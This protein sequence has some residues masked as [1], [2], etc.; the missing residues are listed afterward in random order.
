MSAHAVRERYPEDVE[1]KL[2]GVE[3]STLPSGLHLVDEDIVWENHSLVCPRPR[4]QRR[5]DILRNTFIMAGMR[6]YR[7]E[8]LGILV[9]QSPRPRPWR[10]KASLKDLS[11]RLAD[12]WTQEQSHYHDRDTSNEKD[13]EILK[14]WFEKRMFRRIGEEGRWVGWEEEFGVE[15]E[16]DEGLDYKFHPAL[17]LPHILRILGPSSLTL[18]KHAL[19]QKRIL[20]YTNPPVEPACVLARI[21]ADIVG[22]TGNW[23]PSSGKTTDTR[24]NQLRDEQPLVLGMVGIIDVEKLI[25]HQDCGWIACT[26][27]AIFLEKP[28]LYDL[29]IDMT[30]TRPAR[31]AFFISK[32]IPSSNSL[33]SSGGTS[34]SIKY[35]LVPTRFTFS[36]VRLW[37]EIDRALREEQEEDGPENG[38]SL[39]YTP[40]GSTSSD[41]WD[42]WRIYEDVCIACASAWMGLGVGGSFGLGTSLG[43][44]GKSEGTVWGIGRSGALKVKDRDRMRSWG[45]HSSSSGIR[46]ESE[47]EGPGIRTLGRGI[48]G[49][50][51]SGPVSG[52]PVVRGL[53]SA[54]SSRGSSS[55]QRMQGSSIGIGKMPSQDGGGDSSDIDRELA[56][57]RQRRRQ[58]RTT[59]SLLSIFHGHSEFLCEKLEEVLEDAARRSGSSFDD[60]Y[61]TPDGAATHAVSSLNNSN[62]PVTLVLT[63]RDIA[64]MEL[65]VLSDLDARFLEWLADR[66][67]KAEGLGRRVVVRRGWRDVMGDFIMIDARGTKVHEFGFG[68][69]NVPQ[70][71]TTN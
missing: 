67:C 51:I 13:W 23:S 31:P 1:L 50:P 8:S 21:A 43:M 60:T 44:S 68:S 7:L 2:D 53:R 70:S 61:S 6:G 69:Q 46:L 39:P 42:G 32:A 24:S 14:E 49:R 59:L 19:A 71:S 58:I 18:Y 56:K 20:I 64:A 66:R 25:K 34:S 57:R 3:F 63:P 55:A 17:H 36:D 38:S 33:A 28:A 40:G 62:S 11:H 30:T 26:T 22:V 41:R 45:F 54:S 29:I 48:E 4:I 12:L 15:R 16:E 65:G 27:D 9:A 37:G 52:R 35:R 47:E 10:H 5:L